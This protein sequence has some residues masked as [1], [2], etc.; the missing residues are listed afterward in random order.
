MVPY[1]LSENSNIVVISDSRQ[2]LTCK[3]KYIVSCKNRYWANHIL[4]VYT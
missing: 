3:G 1:S 2:R 4:K